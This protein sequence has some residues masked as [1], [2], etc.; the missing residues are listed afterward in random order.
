MAVAAALL[1]A[2]SV[3]AGVL[4][5]AT[6]ARQ[7]IEIAAKALVEDMPAAKEAVKTTLDAVH[8][9]LEEAP[10]PGGEGAAAAEV[11]A[12]GDSKT[13]T[14]AEQSHGAS[15]ALFDGGGGCSVPTVAALGLA[16][17]AAPASR[18][19]G[20]LAKYSA[21]SAS[22]ATARVRATLAAPGASAARAIIA[23][24]LLGAVHGAGTLPASWSERAL[25][26]TEV[27]AQLASIG[28]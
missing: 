24:G 25:D 13:G 23:G 2:R 7:A 8:A 15:V 20:D 19:G 22:E 28:L 5:T 9:L 6:S 17:A 10:A 18:M 26:M 1:V 14:G 16:A 4:G 21:D 12:E 3:E 11:S 27:K